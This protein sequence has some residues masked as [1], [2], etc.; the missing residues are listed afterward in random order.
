MMAWRNHLRLA[1]T[2]VSIFIAS[3][4]GGIPG[5]VHDSVLS[6]APHLSER[7]GQAPPLRPEYARV[8]FFC[9]GL[10][11]MDKMLF[12]GLAFLDVTLEN[13]RSL[14][15]VE[16]MDQTGLYVDIPAD[17]YDVRVRSGGS[18]TM[19]LESGRHYY[20]K[21]ASGTFASQKI[22]LLEA[23]EAIREMDDEKIRSCDGKFLE[24]DKTAR[25][26][27]IPKKEG[28]WISIAPTSSTPNG[29]I[30][31]FNTKS[32]LLGPLMKLRSG[33]D[34][35]P[36]YPVDSERYV[37]FE[38]TP[39]RHVFSVHAE[40]LGQD[41]IAPVGK[42]V[43]VQEGQ[44]VYFTFGLYQGVK[45]VMPD[46]GQKLLKKYKLTKNGYYGSAG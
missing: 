17:T 1:L 24:D 43:I 32:P 9:P 28:Q 20:V 5:I 25:F 23:P 12:G 34:C 4:C 13:P 35:M 40:N 2:A 10:P 38:V 11:V 45:T 8:A 30:Y 39:G 41:V 27:V 26:A 15:R 33:I 3:G 22:Q 37:C 16:I 7:L 36:T 42:E 18:V 44:D 46:E 31:F 19:T 6:Q 14:L 21:V 29:R